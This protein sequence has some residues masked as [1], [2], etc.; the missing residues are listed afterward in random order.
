[1]AP[2]NSYIHVEDY[3]TPEELYK[4]LDYLNTNDT[5]YLEY[6][7]WR[8]G[9]PDTEQTNAAHNGEVMECGI[10]QNIQMRKKLGYPKR[11]IKSVSKKKKKQECLEPNIL[12]NSI[13]LKILS[14]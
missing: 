2:P 3:A 7:Q 9:T 8:K 1:M 12:E 10:C 4:Y 13:F 6:H 5:A 11:I 14:F